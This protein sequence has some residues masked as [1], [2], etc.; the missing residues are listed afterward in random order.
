LDEL[1]ATKAQHL[2]ALRDR[3]EGWNALVRRAEGRLD[4]PGAEGSWSL[5]QI[6]AHMAG[7]EHWFAVMLRASLEG[8]E[9]TR[10]ELYGAGGAPPMVDD[11]DVEQYNAWI[12]EQ[13]AGRDA[14]SVRAEQQ[15]TSSALIETIDDLSESDLVDP[16]RFPWLNGQ[17][18]ASVLPNQSY[19]H[20][21]AHGESV[22]RWLRDQA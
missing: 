9:A 8:R 10:E 5:K 15:G 22:A 12:A 20:W 1:V 14:A 3:R 2:A 7:Y 6:L 4:E 16:E 19:A 11:F 13:A 21:Q 17:S 18:V